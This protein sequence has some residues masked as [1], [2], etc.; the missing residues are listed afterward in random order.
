MRLQDGRREMNNRSAWRFYPLGV[1]GCMS[2]V[3]AVNFFMAYQA[4]HTVPGK[5]GGDGFDLS[6]RYN[7]VIE[8][9]QK[10]AALGWTMNAV[11]NQERR[12]VVELTDAHGAPIAGA[13][14]AGSAVRPLGANN[15][16][17]LA[18]QEAA[19]GRYVAAAPLPQEGQ[20]DLMLTATAQGHDITATRRIVIW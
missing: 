6:N 20:W 9:V 10:E 15:T 2:V 16:A 13:Q 11:A 1:A 8:R 4:L 12:P 18:F 3:I 7:A 19:P 5:A 14:L 17:T